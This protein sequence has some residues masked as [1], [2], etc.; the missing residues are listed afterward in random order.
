MVRVSKP[1]PKAIVDELLEKWKACC[2]ECYDVVG[3]V[4]SNKQVSNGGGWCHNHCNA[5]VLMHN[6]II[7]VHSVIAHYNALINAFG[8][9]CG[10]CSSVTLSVRKDINR[11][12]HCCIL[13][14]IYIE[15]ASYVNKHALAGS[16]SISSKSCFK[17]KEFLKYVCCVFTIG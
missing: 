15:T 3:I 2:W 4:D 14:F 16:G 17:S 6:E 9:M 11:S 8:V 12:I 5:F 13:I 7:K 1:D 10:N